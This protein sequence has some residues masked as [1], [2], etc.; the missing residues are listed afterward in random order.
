[1]RPTIINSN[2]WTPS[3]KQYYSRY[4]SSAKFIGKS[5]GERLNFDSKWDDEYR[6]RRSYTYS[7]LRD[8]YYP[9]LTIYT[10]NIEMLCELVNDQY[11]ETRLDY[12]TTPRD[13][14][15]LNA[16]S[17]SDQ[18]VIFRSKLF[19]NKYQY[20]AIANVNYYRNPPSEETVIAATRFVEENFSDSRVVY[21]NGKV[22]WPVGYRRNWQTGKT[23]MPSAIPK[24]PTVYTNDESSLFLLKMSWG[25]DLNLVSERVMIV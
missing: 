7:G 17:S 16:L 25:T 1:M 3:F 23:F 11:Y 6:I 4:H 13:S 22:C 10:N 21:N 14:E 24:F 8:G 15:H 20:R 9:A 19:Y 2:K 18:K 5:R 12:I